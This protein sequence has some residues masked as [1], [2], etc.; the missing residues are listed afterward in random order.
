MLP[1]LIHGEIAS[2]LGLYRTTPLADQSELSLLLLLFARCFGF[3][4]NPDTVKLLLLIAPMHIYE[5]IRWQLYPLYLTAMPQIVE[6]SSLFKMPFQNTFLS[7]SL[8]LSTFLV[9]L[10]PM[11][12]PIIQSDVNSPVGTQEI[13]LSTDEGKEFWVKLYYPCQHVHSFN[14]PWLALNSLFV[15]GAILCVPISPLLCLL[16]GL[17]AISL[18]FDL[19][20]GY[21]TSSGVSSLKYYQELAKYQKLP[22]FILSHSNLFKLHCFEDAEVKADSPLPVLLYLHGLSGFRSTYS[23]TAMELAS[24]GYLVICPEFSDGTAVYTKLP[25]GEEIY[26][27]RSPFVEKSKEDV[28]FRYSQLVERCKQVTAAVKFVR[29]ANKGKEDAMKSVSEI[30]WTK[31]TE[32]NDTYSR[33]IQSC[34]GNISLDAPILVGHSFGRLECTV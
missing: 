31:K 10:I 11:I 12:P 6:F 17:H 33:F 20:F 18:V 23:Q 25:K 4:S 15:I 19:S 8:L 2:R 14:G 28:E 29:L 26:Y 7:L 22:Q 5:G 27:K 24:K 21:P 30:R 16:L 3:A 9:F 32:V 34:E 13:C 1:R